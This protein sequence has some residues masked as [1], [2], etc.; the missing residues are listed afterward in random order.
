MRNV[1]KT[2]AKVFNDA[3]GRTPLKQRIDDI[4]GEV[5]ELSRYTDDKNLDEEAGDALCSLIALCEERGHDYRCLIKNTLDKIERRKAQ[6]ASLGRKIKVAILGGAFNPITLG[7]IKLAQFVLNTSA[8][9]DEVW[10]MPCYGHMYGKDLEPA[11]HRLNMCKVATRV[12]GRIKVFQY[13]IDN[14]LSGE[15]FRTVQLLIEDRAYKDKYEFSWIIGQDNANTF[16]K[17]VNY[18][19]LE[20]MIGFVVVPRKGI[21][22]NPK[23]RWYLNRPHIY[24]TDEHKIGDVSS[25]KVRKLLSVPAA[26]GLGELMDEKVLKYIYEYRLYNGRSRG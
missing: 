8:K 22:P 23:V 25:T 14:K 7:H 9:F 13:E 19:H 4:L 17:W 26:D 18:E 6:Y 1:Q 21:K 12:D 5:I 20:R 3:F 2:V 10:L 16:D 11:A 24:L 15:T